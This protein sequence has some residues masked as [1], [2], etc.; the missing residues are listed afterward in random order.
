MP[1]VF[2]RKRIEQT[3]LIRGRYFGGTTAANIETFDPGV[4]RQENSIVTR[5]SLRLQDPIY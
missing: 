2:A 3:L 1:D 4:S 5:E